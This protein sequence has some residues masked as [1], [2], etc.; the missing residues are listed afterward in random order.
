MIDLHIHS[1]YSD[2]SYTVKEILEESEKIGLKIISITDHDQV[3]AYEEL[4]NLNIKKYF[5]GII[6]PGCEF[7]CYFPE[8]EIP[9]EVLGY[10]I[11]I[12]KIKEYTNKI[13]N[14]NIQNRYLQYLKKIGE[15]I[16]L[17][18]DKD[19]KINQNERKFASKVFER[20]ILKY[21]QNKYILDKNNICL[22]PDF[23]RA[24]Q[25][26]KNSIFYINEEKDFIKVKELIEIIH[27]ANG[28]AFLAHP[29]MYK[30][31][32]I[33][34]AIEELIEKYKIDGM[35]CYYTTFSDEQIQI[36]K[37]ICDKYKIFTSGGSDF[38]GL[39]KP[40]IQMGIGYGNLKIEKE[41][42]QSWIK[43]VNN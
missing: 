30:I 38:H 24:A 8:Y 5:S 2:G 23:Y 11:D 1:K 27:N 39:I 40:E 17:I 20:E 22:E 4:K 29:Y 42:I 6:I 34:Q 32:N 9:I 31:D 26:N 10:G 43:L 33:E 25:C 13:K 35:E 37:N 19:L 36:M 15:Q 3:E 12:N 7:K 16:G 41:L 21:E 18:F 14:N 28:L